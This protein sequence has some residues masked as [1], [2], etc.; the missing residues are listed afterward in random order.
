MTV[1]AATHCRKSVPYG[2]LMCRDHWFAIPAPLRRKI[3]WNNKPGRKTAFA[4]NIREA[5]DH[6]DQA[7]Q[8]FKGVFPSG[9]D[10]RY[11][12]GHPKGRE[13][14]VTPSEPPAFIVPPYPGHAS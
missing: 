1:C 13:A 10:A 3:H 14:G 12:A 7:E 2:H 6:I 5:I 8:N 9:R 4:N 11:P